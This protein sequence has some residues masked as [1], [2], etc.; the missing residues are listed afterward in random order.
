MSFVF[1]GVILNSFAASESGASEVAAVESKEALEE[2]LIDAI[3]ANNLAEVQRLI[4]LRLIDLEGPLGARALCQANFSTP[5]DAPADITRVLIAAGADI[6]AWDNYFGSLVFVNCINNHSSDG[7]RAFLVAGV[8]INTCD[9]H[10][11]PVLL[12]AIDGAC[13]NR[14]SRD[15]KWEANYLAIAR[16]LILAGAYESLNDKEGKSFGYMVRDLGKEEWVL[17]ALADRERYISRLIGVSTALHV[18]TP[19]LRELVGIVKDYEEIDEEF[20]FLKERKQNLKK[21]AQAA[22]TTEAGEAEVE[23]KD[24]EEDEKEQAQ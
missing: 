10:G 6:D 23:K 2:R 20:A 1:L 13:R 11:R 12:C 18:C 9:G 8:D 21:K 19:L 17:Q 16:V 4:D 7:A 14:R 3:R 5:L 15:A 24:A 22:V